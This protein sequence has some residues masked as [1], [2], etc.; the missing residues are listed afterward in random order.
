MQTHKVKLG[1]IQR[2]SEKNP[3][4]NLKCT[5]AEIQ[6][7][8]EAGAQIVCTKEL[9]LSDYFCQSQDTDNF[10]LA[11]P[12]PGPSTEQL[13]TLAR[14]KGIV[15]IASLFESRPGDI[16]HNTAAIIDA[17]AKTP[18]PNIPP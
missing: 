7:A 17:R 3:E 4:A 6:S 12:I 5:L 16:Y 8:A 2:R 11:E 14:D 10:N 9:F 15:I 13:C 1:L 18:S